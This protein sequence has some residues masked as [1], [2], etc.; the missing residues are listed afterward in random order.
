[1]E[2][3]SAHGLGPLP[4]PVWSQDWWLDQLEED[5]GA[6]LP[7]PAR[8]LLGFVGTVVDPVGPSVNLRDHSLICRRDDFR[9]ARRCLN[10]SDAGGDYNSTETM[11]FSLKDTVPIGYFDTAVLGVMVGEHRYQHLGQ[12]PIVSSYHGHMLVAPSLE[13]L[14]PTQAKWLTAHAQDPHTEFVL[15]GYP[16]AVD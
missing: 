11:G 2:L 4:E 10:E 8:E 3:L 12:H 14:L 13:A 1:M 15:P 7:D 16:L 9:W 5:L 6:A